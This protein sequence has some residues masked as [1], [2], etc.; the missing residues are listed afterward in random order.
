MLSVQRSLYLS[1]L[2][3]PDSDLYQYSQCQSFLQPVQIQD[4]NDDI[5]D[6]VEL[7]WWYDYVTQFPSDYYLL[8]LSPSDYNN[9]FGD[10]D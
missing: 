1:T 2:S 4:H 6:D 5:I 9:L 7:F 8:L 10:E 3:S